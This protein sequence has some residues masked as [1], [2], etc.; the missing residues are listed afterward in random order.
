MNTI[1][2][3]LLVCS[4]FILIFVIVCIVL[5]C[6]YQSEPVTLIENVFSLFNSEII[7]TFVIW[8]IKKKNPRK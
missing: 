4:L 6:I 2:K 7:L 3:I 5:Y 8:W 1:D